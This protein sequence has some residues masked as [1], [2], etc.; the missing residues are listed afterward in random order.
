[1]LEYCEGLY[2]G[3]RLIGTTTSETVEFYFPKH[4]GRAV[5][6]SPSFSALLGIE[7]GQAD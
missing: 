5:A 7:E 1:M 2:L 4:V 3:L 6:Y